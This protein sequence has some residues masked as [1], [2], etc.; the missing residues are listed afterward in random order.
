L[1]GPGIREGLGSESAAWRRPRGP[2]PGYVGG[3]VPD[4]PVLVRERDLVAFVTN[5]RAF[6]AVAL[7]AVVVEQHNGGSLFGTE[8]EVSRPG[9]VPRRCRD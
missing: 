4:Q 8:L 5:I 1:S 3:L 9:H 7:F 2:D 6:V